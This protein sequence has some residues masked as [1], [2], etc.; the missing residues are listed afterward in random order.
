MNAPGFGLS[1][2][3]YHLPPELVAQYPLP[4][5][6]SCRLMVVDR[7]QGRIEHRRFSD[8]SGY[9]KPQDV[10]CLN[11]SRVR[12][13]RL[14]GR[15]AT[16]GKV[17]VFLLARLAPGQYQALVSPAGRLKPREEIAFNGGSLS[18]RVLERNRV[19]FSVDDERVIYAAG[20]IPLPPYIKRPV[21]PLDREYYQTVYANSEGS[22]AAPTAGLHFT[23]ALLD[24]LARRSVVLAPL[25]LHVGQAT[26]KPVTSE[27]IRSHRMGEERYRIPAA[28][29]AAVTAARAEGR[30]V[31]A[32]GTT[33]CR[34]LESWAANGLL[35]GST[36]LYIY[37]GYAFR[38]VTMLLTN[39]HLPKTTLFVLVCAF[40][41]TELA[42]RAYAQAVDERYRFYSYGDAML[43][44]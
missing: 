13:C 29:A 31:C 12:T 25:T 8:I 44:V 15:R 20:D 22:V 32:V 39:F 35:E 42:R 28:T 30:Q 21:E 27:D 7:R 17:E 43:I 33:S 18:C 16:G 4:E 26:F 11:D 9:L 40:A 38:C 41:G 19:R 24:E 5:R 3:D 10:L 14:T 6:Q 1:D 37:P 34:T 2:Y 36:G 23:V